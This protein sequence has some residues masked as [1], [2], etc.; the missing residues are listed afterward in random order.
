MNRAWRAAAV[1]VLAGAAGQSA[2]AAISWSLVADQ[3]STTTRELRGMA[4]SDDMTNLY[5]GFIQG[6]S[7][8]GFRQYSLSGDPPVGAAG[9]FHS[10][11]T[12]DPTTLRQGEA[13]ATDDRGF[14]FGASIKDSTASTPNARVTMLSGNFGVIKH[15]SLA[16]VTSPPSNSTGETIG[17]LTMRLDSGVRQLYVT[18]FLGNT[19]YIERYVVG[20]TGVADA[21][22]TL[23]STFDGDGTFNLR[24]VVPTADNLRGIDVAGDGTIFVASREDNI[25][26]RISSDL[27]GVSS[28]SVTRAMDVATYADKIYVTQY[29]GTSSQIVEMMQSDLS[30]TGT[31]TAI[32]TFPRTNNTEGYAGIDIDALGRI[33]LADQFYAGTATTTQDRILVSTPLPEP[34]TLSLLALVA[35]LAMRRRR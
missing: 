22:L 11:N 7:T 3:T 26:Y 34:A 23:D 5:A 31:I 10:V 25:V 27:T 17:G 2:H 6:S 28:A 12:V 8:A 29:N 24:A 9:A 4:V 16:D 1:A 13:L 14:V 15:F 19:G 33:F 32:G 20:G 18:R 30:V 21:T 35:P